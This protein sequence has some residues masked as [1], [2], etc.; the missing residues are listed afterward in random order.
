MST[1]RKSVYNQQSQYAP[2]T[3][4]ASMI[5][6]QSFQAPVIPLQLPAI[7]IQFD[8]GL[9]VPSFLSTD[10]PITSLNKAMAFICTSIN[11]QLETLS[12]PRNRVAMQGRQT[13]RHGGNYS[14]GNATGTRVIRY[15]GN[16]TSNRSKEKMLLAQ[17]QEAGIALNEEQLAFLK[18][19]GERID[20]GTDSYTLKLMLSFRH[21]VLIHSIQIMMKYL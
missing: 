9:V 16:S 13:Q 20:L 17:V 18:D 3:H 7:V 8:L 2:V 4:Q 11:N 10:D 12:N 15:M 19:S 6:L 21:M 14:E 5:H 1:M